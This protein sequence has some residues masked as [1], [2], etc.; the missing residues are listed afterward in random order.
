MPRKS[1]HS[2][3]SWLIALFGPFALLFEPLAEPA[4]YP[5]NEIEIQASLSGYNLLWPSHRCCAYKLHIH[6]NGRETVVAN[7]STGEKPSE[8]NQEPKLTSEQFEHIR[9]AL[10]DTDFLKAPSSICCWGVDSDQRHSSVRIG[11]VTHTVTIPDN[12][13]PD[14]PLALRQQ[15]A[16][17][18]ALWALVTE[19]AN[20][21]GA[22]VH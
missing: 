21:P 4:T 18:R 7:V 19:Q 5:P 15:F 8:F 1:L 14:A 17:L 12:L 13:A 9:Q 22:T 3:P 11:P 20:I 2:P 16:N 10:K 6:P